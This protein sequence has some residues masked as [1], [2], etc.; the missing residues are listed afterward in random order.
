MSWQK[1]IPGCFG[2]GTADFGSHAA[3]NERAFAMLKVLMK[4]NVTLG[5]F[6]AEVRKYLKAEGRTKAFTTKQI[7]RITNAYKFWLG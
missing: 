4:E 1:K 3:D 5:Q 6:K 7:T 2:T